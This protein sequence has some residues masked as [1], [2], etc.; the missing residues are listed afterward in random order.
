MP[1]PLTA[2]APATKVKTLTRYKSVDL[3]VNNLTKH[4]EEAA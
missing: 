3:L 4:L 2:K 1:P